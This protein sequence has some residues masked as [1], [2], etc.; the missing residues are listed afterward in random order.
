MS[1]EALLKEEKKK[2][3]EA[4]R[5]SKLAARALASTSAS[6]SGSG[7]ATPQAAIEA[8]ALDLAN[9][10]SGSTIPK[11]SEKPS[12]EQSALNREEKELASN[13]EKKVKGKP[14]KR[15]KRKDKVLQASREKGA[16]AM[17]ERNGDKTSGTERNDQPKEESEWKKAAKEAKRKRKEEKKA[18]KRALEEAATTGSSVVQEDGDAEAERPKKKKRENDVGGVITPA[19]QELATSTSS[20]TLVQ[21]GSQTP[22]NPQPSTM[23]EEHQTYLTSNA[24]SLQAALFPP[25]LDIQALPI[26]SG[27][28][29]YLRQ[30]TKP[31]PIQACSWP[32]LL[33]G[34]DVV[35]IAETGSGKTLAFGVPALQYLSTSH[36]S[37]APFKGSEVPIMSNGK[38]KKSKK[39]NGASKSKGKG[40]GRI[41]VLVLAPTRELAL[42]SHETL[43]A[44]GKGL[45]IGSVCLFGGV[46]KDGQYA[47]L[48]REEVKVVVG[49]PGRTLDL[50]DAGDLDLS[51]LA[52]S[53]SLGLGVNRS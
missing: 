36:P 28:L 18:K 4:K 27:L 3:K 42:Q 10:G 40:K 46:G 26:H 6:P 29:K 32:P 35:G 24:I 38:D 34:R 48:A 19:Q 39:E 7:T 44:A 20:S 15:L 22:S 47:D 23:T 1:D 33:A 30:Y 12:G 5:A 50:A 51:G 13:R 53:L 8:S 21:S 11:S 41:G 14:N 17:Q 37:D 31:T 49:T 9:G 25:Q 43:L 16:L 52:S 2:R 45:G